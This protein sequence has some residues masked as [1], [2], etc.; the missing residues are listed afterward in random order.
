MFL[1]SLEV[2]GFKSFAD[3]TELEFKKGVTAVVGP[4]GSGK[5]NISDSVRWV[6]GEQSVK[7]LRGG[8]MEDVIFAG[9][10]FRKPLG[11][12]QVSLTLDNSDG[13]LQTDYNEIT[14]TRRIFRSGETEYLINNQKCRLKDITELFMDTGIGKE[15]YS[16]IGQ[17]KIDAILSGKAEDR[18]ALLEEAAGIVKYKSRKEEAEKRLDN[19]DNNLVRI[20]DIIATYEER[21]E[22]LRIEKE[23]ALEYREL[24][25]ELRIKEVSLL[26]HNIEEIKKDY[27]QVSTELEEKEKEI[28][29]KRE[30]L[31]KYKENLVSLEKEI[32]SLEEKN[33]KE[34][35]EYYKGREEVNQNEKDVGLFNERVQNFKN[36][37]LKGEEEIKTLKI[38]VADLQSSKEAIEK[39][40]SSKEEEKN[41]KLNELNEIDSTINEINNEIKKF[42]MEIAQLKNEEINNISKNSNLNNLIVSLRKDVETN[43]EKQR[44][45]KVNIENFERN[46]SVN[47]GTIKGL[48]D[49]IQETKETIKKLQEEGISLKKA[50]SHEYNNLSGQ[51]KKLNLLTKKINE[52]E[53]RHNV[54]TNLEKH[55]EGYNRT[56][57]NLMEHVNAGRVNGISEINVVGEI[58]KVEQQYEI[59]IEIALGAAIS[60]VITQKEDDAK[61]LIGFLK[62]KGL[63]R[64][65]FLPL[66]IIKGR[67]ITIPNNVKNYEGYLG[68]ASDLISFDEKYKD[69][70]DYSL[71][72]TLI[73]KD[74]DAALYISKMGQ[75]NYKIVT[76]SGE[77]IN[78]GGALTGGSIQG[79]N[80]NLLG[81]KREIDEL[82]ISLEKQ[83]SDLKSQKTAFEEIKK[84]IKNLDEEILNKREEIHQKNIDLTILDGDVKALINEVDKVKKSIKFSNEELERVVE[85]FKVLNDRLEVKTKELDTLENRNKEGQEKIKSLDKELENR[86]EKLENIR[87]SYT[88]IRVSKAALDESLE[89][90][91]RELYAK[92]AEINEATEKILSLDGEIKSN[93]D[94]ITVLEEG[95]ENKKDTIN[96]LN[97]RLSE[98]EN[99][100]KEDEVKRINLKENQKSKQSEYNLFVEDIKVHENEMNKKAIQNAKIESEQ[101]ALLNKLNSELELTLAEAEEIAVK[102]DNIN[103]VR[104]MVYK[105]KNKIAALGT[106]NLSAIV[107]YDEVCEKYEFMSTQEEDL[108]KAKEELQ[109]VIDEMTIKM[110]E[111]FEENFKILNENFEET[112]KELFNGGTAELI[113]EDGDVLKSNII[114]NVQP[115]GKKL[116]NINLMSGGEKV[117]SAIAL[118]FAILKM[119]PTPFCILDE[120]EAALDDANVY[121]YA[122]FLKKFSKNVQFIVITHRKGTMEAGDVMYGVTMEEKGVSKVVS[123]DLDN[124]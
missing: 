112:F 82:A 40:L 60:N 16:I 86:R 25:E 109:S 71:G 19:T 120:I 20:R 72:R 84:K 77:V 38:K 64:A 2:R 59:A 56:V 22:P 78:P 32:E 114:I 67:R 62:T 93:L 65:T 43:E 115:A 7:N 121:R 99:V 4:N 35:D 53:A 13:T 6:L 15:G 70:I 85:A 18:R 107:E 105:L 57:K 44:N 111:L 8:K 87:N 12:A 45:I 88:D 94:N 34:K 29:A 51:E 27:E 106:V 61:K 119:K 76:L 52:T 81:R 24:A 23:K 55:Y 116:Q 21:L 63:G 36:M 28:N 104:D 31:D 100:F 39:K 11:L 110:K 5:S 91:K 124:E 117:L 102:I 17:G 14:V 47:R 50:L 103:S 42:E 108:E 122:E 113:L 58:F 10:Q 3:K 49:N 73:A 54:L 37:I 80:T 89:G 92:K 26:V 123:V 1:K 90:D 118:L 95:I 33:A 97:K 83:K 96:N 46:L 9:T 98:L 41:N 101:E 74:M 75:H 79:K 68:I 69:I 66:N 30:I 48:E